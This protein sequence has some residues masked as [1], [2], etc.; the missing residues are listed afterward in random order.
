MSQCEAAASVVSSDVPQRCCQHNREQAQLGLQA[1]PFR[2]RAYLNPHSPQ[3][4]RQQH[5][6]VGLAFN[7]CI[8]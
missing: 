2:P 6:L 1:E 5:R 8:L 3:P 4:C 7:H